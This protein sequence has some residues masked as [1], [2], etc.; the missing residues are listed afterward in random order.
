MNIGLSEP[1]TSMGLQEQAFKKPLLTFDFPSLI[2]MI[3]NNPAWLRGEL[4]AMILFK[5]S[6]KQIVLTAM[7]EGTKIISFQSNDSVSFQIL[8]GQLRFHTRY[9]SVILNKDQVLTYQEKTKYSLTARLETV[10]LL[11]VLTNRMHPAGTRYA[12]L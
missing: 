4:N 1:F 2:E 10:M 12:G 8:E 6:D 3:K 5:E 9:E 7:H 11:T